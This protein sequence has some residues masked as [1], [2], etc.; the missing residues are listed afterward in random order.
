MGQTLFEEPQM[1]NQA[2]I[3]ALFQRAQTLKPISA[4]VICPESVVALEGAI[5]ATE[6]KSIVPVLIGDSAKIQ[7]IAQEIGKDISGYQMLNVA[8]EAAMEQAI[9]MVHN[10][11]A[12]TII[13]GSIHS[14]EFLRPI[15]RRESG[16]RTERRMSQCQ[17]YDVPAYKKPLLLTDVALNT[18]PTFAEKKDIIQNAINL[19]IKLGI[20]TPK[21]ALLS[22]VENINPRIPNTAECAEL[23]Q[24]ADAGEITGGIVEGPLSFDLAVSE[25]SVKTKKFQTQVGG[26][27]D[28]LVVPNIEVGNVLMKALNC[29]AGATGFGIV[30]GAK[31][32][33]VLT[34]RAAN[35]EVR[36]GSCV[37][38]KFLCGVGAE[39]VGTSFVV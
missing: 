36:A 10:K 30:L 32:P 3:D 29:F 7:K 18:F 9:A 6:Q 19:A 15:V 24:A 11:E 39:S 16:L 31:V 8:E 27:A 5:L 34:S 1:S 35:A 25:D 33:I 13:K 26:D 22:A 2:K 4:A 12:Q 23:A 14:D 20:V 37:L 28:I 38:A 21:V 17:V